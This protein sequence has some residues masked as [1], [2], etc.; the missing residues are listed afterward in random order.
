M[1]KKSI[2]S[3]LVVFALL[4]TGCANK[5]SGYITVATPFSE[6][7]KKELE[8]VEESY[9]YTAENLQTYERADG[10]TVLYLSSAPIEQSSNKIEESDDTL[11]ADGTYFD[12]TFPR[13]LSEETPIEITGK[14]SFAN[15]YIPDGIYDAKLKNYKN[16]F[17]TTRQGVVY[18][19]VFGKGA[20]YICYPTS[21]GVNTEIKI[22]KKT[23]TNKFRIKLQLP[24]LTPDTNS[25]DYILFKTALD[26]G[27]VESILY[28]PLICDA[29]GKWSYANS[30]RLSEKDAETNTYT[31]EYEVDE[32]FLNDKDTKFP[33]T[34]NQS[35]Y[36]YKSKQPDT[37]AYENTGEVAGHYLSP[38]MLLGDQTSKGE[39][40]T[41]IRFETLE[42]LKIDPEKIISAKYV[43]RN[44]FD[45]EKETKIAAYAVKTDWCSINTRWFN[46]PPHDEQPIG[47]VIVKNAGNYEVDITSLLKVMLQNKALETATYSV[48]NSFFIR[49]DT[50]D[51]NVLIASGDNGLYT[52]ILEILIAG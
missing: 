37:S 38:Y 21:F 50:E 28:T 4:M 49:S 45:S 48:Q 34:L 52:P 25:P 1:N 23:D 46:R 33:V 40:W 3:I 31:V 19:D 9:D 13:S 42:K 8:L 51:S 2:L 24:S 44:L 14:G 29:K 6:E 16:V 43:F 7:L 27:T 32:A 10:S 18:E 17:G 11:E 12:K 36:L 41:Y 39:G 47:E 35:I 22:S 15:I 30:V 5:N 26:N 20:D